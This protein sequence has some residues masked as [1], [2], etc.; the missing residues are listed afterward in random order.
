MELSENDYYNFL[1]IR[2][3]YLKPLNK[4]MSNDEINLVLKKR[5]FN[6]KFFPLPFF[7]T[8]NLDEI[9]SIK[10]KTIIVN[11]KKNFFKLPVLSV[12]RFNKQK[13]IKKLFDGKKIHPYIDFINNSKDYLIETGDISINQS[14]KYFQKKNLVGFATRNIPHKGHEKIILE[15]LKKFKVMIIINSE[16]TKNKK[17]DINKTVEAYLRFIKRNVIKK[18]V[19]LKKILLPSTMLGFRQASLH[20][21][22]GRNFGCDNFII[23]RDHSGFLNYYKEFDSYNFCKKNEKKIGLKILKSGSPL[24]CKNCKKIVFRNE[25]ICKK[26]K[27]DISSTLVRS[28]KNK[29]L[30][31]LISNY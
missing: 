8:A 20:A 1:A 5:V 16:V 6:G 29:K 10:D 31:K 25:C 24:F 2:K 15:K 19:I 26:N 28:L 21:L 12:S 4:F 23:G 30:K 11:F 13:L 3:N 17:T 9:K 22:L 14:D 27:F 7:L 18:K